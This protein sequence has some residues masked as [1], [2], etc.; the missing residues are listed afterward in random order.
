MI[1]TPVHYR[2]DSENMYDSKGG[3]IEHTPNHYLSADMQK[4]INMH[5]KLMCALCDI[6][7]MCIGYI[8]IGYILEAETIGQ[9]ISA[10]TGLTAPELLEN[11]K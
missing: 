3:F 7:Q 8:T 11:C 1:N 4:R 9:L 10:A 2:D 5:N 6:Q